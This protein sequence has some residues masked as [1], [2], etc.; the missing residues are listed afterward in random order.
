MHFVSATDR[1]VL[2]LHIQLFPSFQTHLARRPEHHWQSND[3][4]GDH[5][6]RE[7]RLDLVEPAH[8]QLR[9]ASDD[10]APAENFLNPLAATHADLVSNRFQSGV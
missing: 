9:E 3:V 8:F 1:R 7:D 10:L 5:D 6:K 2:L 4:A